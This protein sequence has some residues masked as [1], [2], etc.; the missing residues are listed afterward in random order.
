MFTA[1]EQPRH[2]IKK[3]TKS[4]KIDCSSSSKLQRFKNT[5]QLRARVSC[6]IMRHSVQSR[7]ADYRRDSSAPLTLSPSL[8]CGR[9]AAEENVFRN[10]REREP[11]NRRRGA[12]SQSFL[13]RVEISADSYKR[14][15][16]FLVLSFSEKNIIYV[17]F[18]YNVKSIY[19]NRNSK[20][21]RISFHCFIRFHYNKFGGN[22]RYGHIEIFFRLIDHG[23]LNYSLYPFTRN[24]R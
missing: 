18:D 15:K 6:G 5:F 13:I 16:I 7:G 22:S 24:S 23:S 12:S 8:S 3:K 2:K 20:Q 10:I 1:V 17:G 14:E 4:R 21:E 19:L 9:D 11:K